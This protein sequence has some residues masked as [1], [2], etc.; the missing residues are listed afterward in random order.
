[1]NERV[2]KDGGMMLAEETSCSKESLSYCHLVYH[3]SH[4]PVD[5]PEI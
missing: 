3:N 5:L 4:I 1:M 2:W